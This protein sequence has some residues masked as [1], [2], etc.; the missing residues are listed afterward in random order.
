MI[1]DLVGQVLGEDFLTQHLGRAHT[2]YRAAE[3]QEGRF[4]RL[5]T[6][7]A[8]NTLLGTHRLEPPRLRLA[9]D[10][11]TIPTHLYCEHR[12]YR[13]MPPW[14]APL[15]HLVAEQLRDGATLVLD[16]VEEMHPP[17]NDLLRALSRDLRTGVQA[18][19]YASWTST[20][21]FGTHWDD[22]DV[23]V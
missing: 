10:S 3:G 18:N 2:M 17:I 22:H 23:I 9:K 4:T 21:G 12:T 11:D 19:A 8:L 13:R 6:W 5:L 1:T 15:A 20:E 16:A 7:Q 14:K